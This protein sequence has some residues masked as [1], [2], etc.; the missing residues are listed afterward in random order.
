MTLTVEKLISL[1]PKPWIELLGDD[2]KEREYW[3]NIVEKLNSKEFYPNIRNVFR[4]LE[5]VSP[6]NVKCIIIG[7]DPYINENQ[8]TGLSFSVPNGQTI[9]PS[10]K[11]IYKELFTEY[12]KD[13][14]EKNIREYIKKYNRCGN[15]EKLC[16]EG[17]LF[18]N[19]ILTVSPGCSNSHKGIGW[20]LFTEEVLKVLDIKYK[21]VVMCWGRQAYKIARNSIK[22][23]ILLV[24]GHPS[25][26]NSFNP[27]VGCNCFKN[28]NEILKNKLQLLPIKWTILFQ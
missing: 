18:L 9:P 21:F 10:L 11:N 22:F 1:I 28:C 24:T 4:A 16:S 5:L 14:T 26:L 2:I 8:A 23:N 19:S 12:L 6:E 13:K 17:V 20:E 25:P 27:F 3:K 7:Q 15:L